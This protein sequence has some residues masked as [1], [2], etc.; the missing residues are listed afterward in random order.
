[1]LLFASALFLALSAQAPRAGVPSGP[2]PVSNG[3]VPLE[4]PPQAWIYYDYLEHGEL[5]GGTVRIDP[6]NPLHAE[7]GAETIVATSPVTTLLANGPS[8]NRIDLVFVGDGYRSDELGQY[9]LDVDGVWPSL[10]SEPPLD[11]YASYFNIHRV[12]VSSPESGVDND[13]VQGI[14]KQTALD[15]GYWCSGTQRLLCVNVQKANTQARLAPGKD[16]VLALANS[17]T[18]GG[19]GYSSLGTLAGRNGS[20][21]EIALHEFGHSF[22][23]LADEY[24]YGGPA[25]YTGPEPSEA[26]VTTHTEAELLAQGLKWHL[27]LDLPH[28]GT[29]EGAM[30][31][32]FGI[33][34]PT[35]NSKMRS[36]GRPFEEVNAERL[37]R[38]VYRFVRPIDAATPAGKHA[39]DASFFVD[40]VDPVGHALDVQWSLDGVAIPGATGHTF[41][42]ANLALASG[43]HV[44]SVT[45][46]DNTPLVRNPSLRASYLTEVRS[47]TLS[48]RRAP[49]AHGGPLAP[50]GTRTP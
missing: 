22:A 5:R 13:P 16:C 32:R 28:V 2:D 17:S 46:V 8:A 36:L 33:Y 19:A 42:S 20:A 1:M 35:S 29:F 6:A 49:V 24:D 31:S 38:H 12:D 41:D 43:P 15:M 47:W 10:L 40:P 45:V 44:L 26:D 34:R 21:I 27:W 50:G 4:D 14:F 23:S 48:E 11:A 3:E 18:Y 37:V 9:A 39:L 25:S 30:Y 7:T